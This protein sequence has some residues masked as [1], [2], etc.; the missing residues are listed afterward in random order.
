MQ[1]C[2]VC[3]VAT[4]VE[5]DHKPFGT[6]SPEEAAAYWTPEAARERELNASLPR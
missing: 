2:R 3:G 4:N 6:F 1:P 5:H